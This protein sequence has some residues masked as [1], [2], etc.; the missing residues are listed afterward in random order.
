MA[1]RVKRKSYKE[2]HIS[3]SE[4]EQD[5]ETQPKQLFSIIWFQDCTRHSPVLRSQIC[6]K[7][8]QT[9]A[10]VWQ[11]GSGRYHILRTKRASKAAQTS[12]AERQPTCDRAVHP[13]STREPLATGL[14]H[15]TCLHSYYTL[16]YAPALTRLYLR[17]YL[18]L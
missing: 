11:Q 10:Q 17:L 15:A 6:S 7:A 13:R 8:V 9:A 4:G 12:K 2:H 18:Q 1:A 5:R 14:A 16:R 3:V